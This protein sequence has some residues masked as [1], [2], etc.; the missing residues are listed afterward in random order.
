MVLREHLASRVPILR[1]LPCAIMLPYLAKTIGW[2]LTELGH[3]PGIVF[4]LQHTT[5]AVSLNLPLRVL[6]PLYL[7][8]RYAM[9][10]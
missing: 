1:L 2:M 9:G 5:Q 10:S 4:G 7:V 8:F 6:R 3:Q